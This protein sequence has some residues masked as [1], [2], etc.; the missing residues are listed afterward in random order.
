MIGAILAGGFGKRLK[1]LTDEIPKA[2]IQIRENYSILDR[3][4]FDFKTI[5]IT[6]IYILSGYMGEKIQERY[7]SEEDGVRF[8]YLKEDKPMGTLYSMRNLI[9]HRSDEDVLLRNG[10]TVTDLNFQKFA[11]FSRKSAFD[12]TM[13]VSRMRSPFGIVEL[14][15]DQILSFKEKPYLNHYINSGVY[16]IKKSAFPYFSMD[17]LSKDIETTV[18]P[19]I[20]SEKKAGAYSEETLWLGIDSE[21]DLEQIRK[22]YESRVDFPWGYKKEVFRS[23]GKMIEDYYA[24]SENRIRIEVKGNAILRI[25]SGRGKIEGESTI[26]YTDNQIL[27]VSSTFELY[28][29]ENTWFSIISV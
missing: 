15:G 3:Q 26:L 13:F 28:P 11:E 8:T 29:T 24:R 5:G 12:L 18:F 7:G 1:P 23:G 21:K 14:L 2:M 4:I 6:D 25:S 10:D 9:S 27:Q 17:Y 20:A 19:R 22:E 16:Y